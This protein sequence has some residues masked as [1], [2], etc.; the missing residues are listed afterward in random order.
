MVNS[1]FS[2]EPQLT[3]HVR[4]S[5]GHYSSYDDPNALCGVVFVQSKFASKLLYHFLKD[6]SRSEDTFSFLMPQYATMIG[7]I[8]DVDDEDMLDVEAEKR[9]QEEALRRFRMKEC[10]ILISNSLIEVGID[11]VRLDIL[12]HLLQ[13]SVSTVML[14]FF[15]FQVKTYN[16]A[17]IV[18]DKQFFALLDNFT[19]Y[20]KRNSV[21]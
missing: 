7:D 15:I 2:G 1:S 8:N 21:G 12:S 13:F 5:R 11:S 10:N 20:P 4:R 3:P 6:L 16:S 14:F 18:N 19:T 9:K 17:K